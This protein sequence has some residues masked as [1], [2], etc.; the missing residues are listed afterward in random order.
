MG[1]FSALY[2]AEIGQA[3][4]MRSQIIYTG[5]CSIQIKI[6]AHLIL[7]GLIW[8]AA[9][10][11]H[12]TNNSLFYKVTCIQIIACFEFSFSHH[13]R[14]RVNSRIRVCVYNG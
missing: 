14:H 11:L 12:Y 7:P 6:P 1:L 13:V 9:I 3:N 4:E 8:S 10:F 2:C 5:K